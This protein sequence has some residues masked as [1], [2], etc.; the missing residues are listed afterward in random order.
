MG[1][2]TNIF[3]SVMR[4]GALSSL[5]TSRLY[6]NGECILLAK[7]LNRVHLIE[8]SYI[9]LLTYGKEKKMG[10]IVTLLPQTWIELYKLNT[11]ANIFEISF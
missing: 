10:V 9:E 2:S 5:L 8:N 6:S 7:S 4:M 1:R 3:C 11:I